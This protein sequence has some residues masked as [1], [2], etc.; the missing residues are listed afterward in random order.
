MRNEE[1]FVL[2]RKLPEVL[3]VAF[4]LRLSRLILLSL[5]VLCFLLAYFLIEI[6]FLL[7]LWKFREVHHPAY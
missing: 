6:T 5:L 4:V 2:S 3:E 1:S 7:L